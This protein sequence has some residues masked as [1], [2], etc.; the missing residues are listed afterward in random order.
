MFQECFNI[1]K[2]KT[3]ENN[4]LLLGMEYW[5]IY[6]F[7]YDSRIIHKLN[8]FDVQLRFQELKINENVIHNLDQESIF[9][10]RE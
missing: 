6:Y 8:L 5:N 3:N 4:L 9:E 10:H 1:Q 7:I 2:S